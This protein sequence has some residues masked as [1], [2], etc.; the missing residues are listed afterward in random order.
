ML[1]FTVVLSLKPSVGTW[2]IACTYVFTALQSPSSLL[3]H[4][5]VDFWFFHSVVSSVVSSVVYRFWNFGIPFEA[6]WNWLD[7]EQLCQ[8][9]AM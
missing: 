9:L 1:Q 6:G 8:D 4:R 3:L 2:P 5:V 7:G